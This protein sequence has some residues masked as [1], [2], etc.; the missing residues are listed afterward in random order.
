MMLG[1]IKNLD[2]LKWL[3]FKGKPRA[4]R[5]PDGWTKTTGPF[6]EIVDAD[7]LQCCHCGGHFEVVVGS[8]VERG[9]CKRCCGYV[10][11]KPECMMFCVPRDQ[12]LD[13]L[14]HGL[15]RLHQRPLSLP[16]EFNPYGK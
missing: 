16:A 9:F 2:L 1:F 12:Q 10:C 6:G 14:E 5:K 8:G 15:P 11:G 7:T 4:A 13:N 3:G